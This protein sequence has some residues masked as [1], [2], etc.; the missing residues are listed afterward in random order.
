MRSTVLPIL[1]V[2]LLLEIRNYGANVGLFY[3]FELFSLKE[4]CDD[5]CLT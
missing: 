5:S 3:L 2:R 4:L 1:V